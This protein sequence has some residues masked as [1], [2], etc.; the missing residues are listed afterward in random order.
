[1]NQNDRSDAMSKR[2]IDQRL[3]FDN[4]DGEIPGS[5][6]PPR[7]VVAYNEMRSCHDLWTMYERE[8]LIIDPDFQRH[9]VWSVKDRSLFIDSLLK[10]LPIPSLCLFYDAQRGQKIV[11]DGLQRISAIIALLDPNQDWKVSDVDGVDE[12][13]RGKKT[14][15]LRNNSDKILYQI[16]EK[17]LPITVIRGDFGKKSHQDYLVQIFSRLNSGGRRLLNQEVRNCIYRGS[18]NTSLK[19]MVR[20][21]KWLSTFGLTEQKVDNDRFGQEEHALRLFAFY[22]G[23]ESYK[24]GLNHFLNKTMGE[25][26]N[27]KAADFAEFQNVLF[28]AFDIVNEISVAGDTLKKNWNIREALL[29]GVM[30]NIDNVS[31]RDKKFLNARYRQFLDEVWGEE[32]REGLMQPKKVSFRMNTS[33]RI[34]GMR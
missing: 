23:V 13:I 32:M 12:R 6:M 18:L 8:Q 33:S 27:V 2:D 16:E 9:N 19:Q 14:S 22:K 29:V 17:I 31:L 1:M 15:E 4:E 5:V 25:H 20:T 26:Q 28:R 7:D 21:D 34:F 30:K 10:E 24:K 11:V 3:E